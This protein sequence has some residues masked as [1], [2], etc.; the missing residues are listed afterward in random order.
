MITLQS[1][2]PSLKSVQITHVGEDFEKN[3]FFYTFGGNVN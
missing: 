2:W 1:E 3:E